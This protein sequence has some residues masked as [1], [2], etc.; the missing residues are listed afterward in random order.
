MKLFQL[1]LK[2]NK[3]LLIQM[4]IYKLLIGKDQID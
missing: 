2:Q 1:L 4:I 3:I